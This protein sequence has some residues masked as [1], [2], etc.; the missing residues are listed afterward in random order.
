M[1]NT[2]ARPRIPLD[3]Y[4]PFVEGEVAK[5]VIGGPDL[6]VLDY[7]DDCNT[8]DVAWIDSEGDI[9]FADFPGEAIARVN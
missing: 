6:L 1:P 8:V 5:L 9:Q 4:K 3:A 2:Q 7:S